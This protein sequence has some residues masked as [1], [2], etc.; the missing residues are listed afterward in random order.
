MHTQPSAGIA[1]PIACRWLNESDRRSTLPCTAPISSDVGLISSWKPGVGH[2]HL[3]RLRDD[4]EHRALRLEGL[5]HELR[6]RQH[7]RRADL[8]REPDVRR[9]LAREEVVEREHR[10]RH[11]A[12]VRG[13]RRGG[14]GGG[15]GG[16]AERLEPR[17]HGVE[18][19]DE[20]GEFGVHVGVRRR[21]RRSAG[22][23]KC[24]DTPMHT[25]LMSA[26]GRHR[27]SAQPR[28]PG[29]S[30]ATAPRMRVQ[31]AWSDER[32]AWGSGV[33]SIDDSDLVRIDS[34]CAS[35]AYSGSQSPTN[36]HVVQ[37]RSRSVA[38]I[39]ADS[40]SADGSSNL[41]GS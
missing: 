19:R 32:E 27:P 8:A 40:E 28:S 37:T 26:G 5:L 23:A 22:D 2:R 25:M 38:A 16:G 10:R 31:T 14:R 9:H 21:N 20:G 4:E 17:G 30:S 11:D 41:P 3:L 15:G 7:V 12:V 39:T 1:S 34:M 18:A 6:L 29:E 33:G 13:G 24:G 35:R 36:M